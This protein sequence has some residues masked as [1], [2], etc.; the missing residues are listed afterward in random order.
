MSVRDFDVKRNFIPGR[1]FS[2]LADFNEQLVAW[3]AEIADLRV[4]GTTHERPI[5]RFVREASAL[6]CT[7]DHPSFF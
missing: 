6:V 1:V 7:L 4:H 5:E 2:D 3:L